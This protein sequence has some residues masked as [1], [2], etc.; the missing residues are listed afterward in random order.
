[1]LDYMFRRGLVAGGL[2]D[3]GVDVN[4][5]TKVLP[6]NILKR[7][8]RVT[9]PVKPRKRKSV[10]FSEKLVNGSEDSSQNEEL[11]SEEVN[12]DAGK[13]LKESQDDY[14]QIFRVSFMRGSTFYPRS[15][16][17]SISLEKLTRK[18]KY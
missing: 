18:N 5:P 3:S 10:T 7:G 4:S 6:K 12:I 15:T 8:V 17:C 14:S 1:M 13:K 9:Q 2:E 16:A 11:L